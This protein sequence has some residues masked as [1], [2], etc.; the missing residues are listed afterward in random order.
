MR[1]AHQREKKETK[2]VKKVY[3]YLEL[4]KIGRLASPQKSC[5]PINQR[6]IIT[7]EILSVGNILFLW[8][9]ENNTRRCLILYMHYPSR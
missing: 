6:K 4:D 2:R 1:E 5:E 7:L 8:P 3:I 9:T